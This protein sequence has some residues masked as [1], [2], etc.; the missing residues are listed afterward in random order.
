MAERDFIGNEPIVSILKPYSIGTVGA[1][2][3]S[4]KSILGDEIEVADLESRKFLDGEITDNVQVLEGEG[5]GVGKQQY[6]ASVAVTATIK[7]KWLSIGNAN[8]VTAPNVRRGEEVMIYR[9]GNTDKYY[10]D[11][12]K[13]HIK[14]R[15]LET[16][17][18]AFSGEADPSKE[19]S[20]EN[21]NVYFF[22]ISTHTKSVLFQTSQAN[23]EPFGHSLQIDASIG[24]FI[25]ADTADNYFT[26][27]SENKLIE[28]RNTDGTFFRLNGPDIEYY[29]PGNING[30]AEGNNDLEVGGNHSAKVSGNTNMATEGSTRI[31]SQ[32][33]ATLASPTSADVDSPNIGFMG[34][35]HSANG[36]YGGDGSMELKGKAHF[37]NDIDVDGKITAQGDIETKNT[38]I[39]VNLDIE[40]KPWI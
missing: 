28:M 38:F 20:L 29:A 7:A 18:Y 8:R 10:W 26:V 15:R 21:E 32:G 19:A 34:A 35:V 1:N 40:N 39:G 5:E 27:E 31:E 16:V 23:G 13:N 25:Y 4:D 24:K 2:K 3:D 37:Q 22:Q 11:T 17:V 9:L 33:T 30:K 6:S 14:L 12:L 36:T